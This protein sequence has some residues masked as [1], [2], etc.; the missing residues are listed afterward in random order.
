MA[1]A[2][3]SYH[4]IQGVLLLGVMDASDPRALIQNGLW[5]LKVI[6]LGALTF[7]SF[8]L[9]RW[10]VAGLYY[11]AL[12][13]GVVFLLIQAVLLV[14]LAY[15]W[16]EYMV[17]KVEEGNEGF[18]VILV[19]S[20]LIFNV[21]VL[22]GTGLLFWYFERTLDRTLLILSF[23]LFFIITLCSILPQVQDANPSAGIFQSSL[24][25]LYSIF[26]LVGAFVQDPDIPKS[27][28]GFAVNYPS[29]DRIV[30]IASF[31]YAYVSVS[32]AAF[33]TGSNMHRMVPDSPSKATAPLRDDG[34]DDSGEYDYAMFHISFV[35]AAFYTALYITRWHRS[36][37]DGLSVILIDT[38]L[39]FWIRVAT[40]WGVCGLYLWSLFA[41]I[42]LEDRLF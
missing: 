39:G 16:A 1:F 37:I 5:P 9:P 10:F 11:P 40:S 2:L 12:I 13:M 20:T 27:P 14:D 26:V 17:D 22:G 38:R 7:F 6:L 36:V 28:S 24:L 8:Y 3:A 18:K 42:I 25:G 34:D 19:G 15:N 31:F 4:M 41:P 35:L 21:I 29:L 30:S 23:L 32:Y 33:N